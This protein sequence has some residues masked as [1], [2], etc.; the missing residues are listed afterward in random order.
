M[1]KLLT[2]SALFVILSGTQSLASSFWTA[3][4]ETQ[5]MLSGKRQI[6]PDKYKVYTLD[7]QGLKNQLLNAPMEF[8]MAAKQSPV[9]I[10]LPL[11]G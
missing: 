1:R 2:L 9:V 10:T 7:V 4:S 3:K 8:T 5:E 11:M 6:V